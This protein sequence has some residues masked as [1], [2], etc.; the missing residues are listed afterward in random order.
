MRVFGVGNVA[1]SDFALLGEGCNLKV[2]LRTRFFRFRE[3]AS[4]VGN[5]VGG[6]AAAECR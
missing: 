2:V 5:D 4:R 6:S 1:L 3:E